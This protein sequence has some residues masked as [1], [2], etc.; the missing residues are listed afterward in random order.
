MARGGRKVPRPMFAQTECV[1][2]VSWVEWF[3]IV[4]TGGRI[5]THYPDVSLDKPYFCIFS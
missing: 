1:N 3:P 2:Q 4:K 5:S